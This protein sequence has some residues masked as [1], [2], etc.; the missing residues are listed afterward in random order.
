MAVD[1]PADD[2]DLMVLKTRLIS[3]SF[4]TNLVECFVKDKFFC[5]EM[6]SNIPQKLMEP[7]FAFVAGQ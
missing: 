7:L 4:G 5:G 6:N 1:L 3:K 2:L